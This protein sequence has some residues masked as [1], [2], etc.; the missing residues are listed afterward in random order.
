MQ[1][2]KADTLDNL[3]GAQ[4]ELGQIDDA[5]K[6]Y[7][8]ALKIH[9]QLNDRKGQGRSL[10][11]IGD[12][13]IAFG[14]YDLALEYLEPALLARQ[15]ANDG[16]GQVAVLNKIGNI[17]RR[18]GDVDGALAAHR[19]AQKL[20]T[21]P[22]E[23]A[24]G[25]LFIAR[26]LLADRQP[27]AA[28]EI[29][30]QVA[31][32][33]AA[34]DKRRL[35]ADS[36]MI[37]GDARLQM[38]Q[39]QP[40]L[41]AFQSAWRDYLVLGLGVEQA[42]A[43]FST[44]RAERQLGRLTQALVQAEAAVAQVE[45]LRSQLIAPELRAFFLSARQEY[46]EFLIDLLMTLHQQSG[47]EAG[48]YLERALAVSE[49][50]RARAL[51]DL[52]AEADIRAGTGDSSLLDDR[53]S[54]LYRQ[55]AE[56]RYR[57]D[58]LA[59][60]GA[61]TAEVETIKQDLARIENQLN[62]MQIEEREAN[63][64]LAGL[65]NPQILDAE[66]IRAL[67]SDDTALVQYHL[68]EDRS[69]AWHLTGDSIQGTA[70]PGR[71]EIEVMAREAYE[72]LQ[73]PA[74][75]AT[76]RAELDAA[77]ARLSD[78][79]LQP[80]GTIGRERIIVVSDGVLQYLP[81]SILNYQGEGPA[82]G[83]L[84][85]NFEIVHLPSMST[86]QAQRQRSGQRVEPVREIAIFADPVFSLEDARLGSNAPDP[87]QAQSFANA[88]PDGSASAIVSRQPR[89]Q[90]LRAT[91][92]EADSIAGLVDPESRMMAMGFEANRDTVLQSGLDQYRIV[93]F[94]T[95]GLI[96]SR[97]PALSALAFSSF[98][99]QGRP[100]DSLLRLH[101]IYNLNLNADL[102][103]L[104]ACSTA[105]GR[106]ISGEGLTGMTQGLMYSGS[107][108]VLA[109]LW[110]VPDR[111]TAELMMRFY[112]NLL[113][114]GQAPASALRNAQLELAGTTRWSSPYFWSAFVLQGEW[115]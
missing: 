78:A 41:D 23:R 86:L 4:R 83:P 51:V 10:A 99:E 95:H 63:P 108:S 40:A 31:P 101:D 62:L 15:A 22:I 20:V 43:L 48:Q 52:I 44:A 114:K 96:D 60:S 19:E 3:G 89:L 75:T 97:Y 106:E 110:Q 25:Q 1:R 54:E 81:F 100:R 42:Q 11:G 34:T 87:E 58:R 113:E 91:S 64:R 85:A 30:D 7:S 68:G 98:D 26:D 66:Q 5:L 105:L 56:N 47:D 49:R 80:L 112:Q 27:Q 12:T 16:R 71:S 67:L 24:R 77:L 61:Q 111:A 2:Y 65:T 93:H 13:Y 90:R 32:Q 17:K 36:A 76:A 18:Q 9:E 92:V 103:A 82:G 104:S 84:L 72:K 37:R 88:D 35:Q 115:L 55:M 29:L 39:P 8:E 102:V 74:F 33:T 70:L 73:A 69:Y 28:L 6:S 53:R 57:I 109:S 59:E 50:S 46:Y 21:A 45:G 107:R 94:A 14:E 79:I 38:G